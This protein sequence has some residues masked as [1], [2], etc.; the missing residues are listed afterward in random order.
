MSLTTFIQQIIQ[1]LSEAQD[2]LKEKGIAVGEIKDIH[3]ETYVS[4]NED[5]FFV[6]HKLSNPP[7]HKI[8]ITIPNLKRQEESFVSDIRYILTAEGTERLM[9]FKIPLEVFLNPDAPQA[10]IHNS[11]GV[12][13]LIDCKDDEKCP[14]K[15]R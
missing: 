10:C 13:R 14:M 12:T 15:N 6:A 2:E 11:H 9:H 7:L 8:T 1:Q 3:I 4:V 5:Y